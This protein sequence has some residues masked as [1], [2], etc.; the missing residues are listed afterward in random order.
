MTIALSIFMRDL[1]SQKQRQLSSEKATAP[2]AAEDNTSVASTDEEMEDASSSCDEVCSNRGVNNNAFTIVVDNA[3]PYRPQPQQRKHKKQHSRRQL[4]RERSS[5]SSSSSGSGNSRRPQTKNQARN[6]HSSSRHQHRSRCGRPRRSFSTPECWSS[7]RWDAPACAPSLLASSYSS[8]DHCSTAFA[9]TS[10]TSIRDK[11]VSRW[12][13]ELSSSLALPVSKNSEEAGVNHANDCEAEGGR[14]EFFSSSSFSLLPQQQRRRP[15]HPQRSYSEIA[16][17]SSSLSSSRDTGMK[18]RNR[19]S[20]RGQQQGLGVPPKRQLSDRQLL[21]SFMSPTKNDTTT[22]SSSATNANHNS[23]RMLH[24]L[25]RS[26]SATTSG[27][28]ANATMPP[29]LRALPY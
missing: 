28:G 6:N 23:M 29:S 9:V 27:G 11:R 21:L 20:A 18:T 15:R 13:T 19:G 12:E 14:D 2:A 4:L 26:T 25:L 24:P 22:A 3:R 10:P 5:S 8:N 1:L 16:T 7:S 17:T